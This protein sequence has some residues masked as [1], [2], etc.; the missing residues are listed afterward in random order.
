M[1]N[2]Q[3]SFWD[4]FIFLRQFRICNSAEKRKSQ[5]ILRRLGFELKDFLKSSLVLRELRDHSLPWNM[6]FIFLLSPYLRLCPCLFKISPKN[7][8]NTLPGGLIKALKDFKH[9]SF[10]NCLPGRAT[11]VRE[12]YNI[13][14]IIVNYTISQLNGQW[15]SLIER[16]FTRFDDFKWF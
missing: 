1:F 14:I 7:G 6:Q 5:K 3:K 11:F 9:F 2:C 13:M 4:G 15:L 12:W 8:L 16:V 10:W